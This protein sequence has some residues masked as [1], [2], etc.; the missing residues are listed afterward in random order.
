MEITPYIPNH[1]TKWRWVANFTLL[2]RGKEP[3][4][5][6]TQGWGSWGR[7]LEGMKE[8]R[9]YS[10]TCLIAFTF[11]GVIKFSLTWMNEWN[12][13]MFAIFFYITPPL[14]WNPQWINGLWN[15]MATNSWQQRGKRSKQ[16]V[17]FIHSTSLKCRTY[18]HWGQRRW[19]FMFPIFYLLLYFLHMTVTII[20]LV[21]RMIILS[22]RNREKYA[23]WGSITSWGSCGEDQ[24]WHLFL[25]LQYSSVL[26]INWTLTKQNM[27]VHK[28]MLLQ[29]IFKKNCSFMHERN[30]AWKKEHGSNEW[31]RVILCCGN[32]VMLYTCIQ[33]P[34]RSWMLTL[35]RLL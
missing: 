13:M 26:L 21:N 32:T 7:P 9:N 29:I 8:Q 33:E 6:W 27:F 25:C 15:F 20:I 14:Y 1:G 16:H 24:P 17:T 31:Y 35:L 4:S 28:Q 5:L 34:P 11:L 18:L 23:R 30:Y 12:Y 22:S 19:S 2:L 10:G 3:Q